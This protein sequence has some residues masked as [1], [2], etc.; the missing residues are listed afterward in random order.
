MIENKIIKNYDGEYVYDISLDGTIINALGMNVMKQTDGFNFSM[1]Q[2]SDIND[3]VYIGKGLNRNTENGK[4]YR[5]VYADVAE[6]ND[7]FMR[8]KMGLG[9]DEFAS[10]TVN[11]SRKNYADLLEGGKIK[12][13]GN[14]IK[15]KKMPIYIEKFV[16]KGIKLL[17]NNNG[18]EFLETYYDY[19]DK[20]FN[21]QIPLKDIASK[22][23]IKKSLDEYKKDCETIT[24]AGRPKN[25]QVWYELAIMEGI[26]PDIGDTIY[27]IN[28]GDGK[29][30]NTYKD[31]EKKKVKLDDG[32]ETT[33][34]I[35]NCFML[36]Q[37]TVESGI[38]VFCT[39]D[40]EYN[41]S[42]YIEQFNNRVKPLLVV[43]NPEIRDKIIIKNPEDRKYFTEQQSTL[44]SGNPYKT[45]DQDSYEALMS[46]ED[47]EI[48]FWISFGETP[49]FIDECGMNW[50]DIVNDYTKRM[51]DLKREDIKEEAELYNTIIDNLTENDV[52]DFIL[53]VELPKE[54][55]AF[56]RMDP[57]TMRLIS[58]KHNVPIGSAYDISDKEFQEEDNEF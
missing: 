18:R 52:D 57:K 32:T 48:S 51:E 14:T 54:I 30:K 38:D 56:L 24:K 20:I 5:G 47:K 41:S 17:L 15:S 44:T 58:K 13:V 55:S 10:A 49:P 6:F 36:D 12:L 11:L 27:Y 7:L 2:D 33:K 8:N 9:I 39:D 26:N 1:P 43:F 29:K 4:E 40:L 19:I 50:D 23:K 37:K 28:T 46:M 3:R 42:K 25:R 34:L 16:D 31:V 35:I 53:N 22:G 45:E 21:Y